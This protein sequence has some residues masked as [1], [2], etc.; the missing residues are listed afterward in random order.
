MCFRGESSSMVRPG[1]TVLLLRLYSPWRR[2]DSALIPGQNLSLEIL[3][4]IKI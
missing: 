1:I 2:E 4:L 3:F